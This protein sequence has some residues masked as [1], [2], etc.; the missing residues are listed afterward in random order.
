MEVNLKGYIS[1]CLAIKWL[2]DALLEDCLDKVNNQVNEN[3]VKSPHNAWVK[4]LRNMLKRL[5]E[6]T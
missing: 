6:K 4:F 1:W 3:Q 5:D 2:H